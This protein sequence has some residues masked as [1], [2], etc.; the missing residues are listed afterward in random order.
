MKCKNRSTRL[1]RVIDNSAPLLGA[2]LR[3]RAK[4][5][6]AH[7]L[8]ACPLYHALRSLL[9][10]VISYSDPVAYE[11]A[12]RSELCRRSPLHVHFRQ[13]LTGKIQTNRRY[14]EA[15]FS[16]PSPTPSPISTFPFPSPP[17]LI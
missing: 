14:E 1:H 12:P 8:T 16:S 3:A 2:S 10:D 9:P 13:L 7:F 17:L 6:E 15:S 11:R 4:K 5:N